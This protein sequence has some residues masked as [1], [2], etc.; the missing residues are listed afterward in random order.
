M[1]AAAAPAGSP[2]PLFMWTV[3]AD[4]ATVHLLGSVHVGAPDFYPLDV[5]I[6]EAFAASDGLAVEIDLTDPATVQRSAQLFLQRAMY[7]ADESLADHV[8]PETYQAL[9][10][11][12]KTRP[13]PLMVVSRM[14]PAAVAVFLALEEM[15]RL[16][17]DPQLGVDVHFLNRARRSCEVRALETVEQQIDAIFGGAAEVEE[18]L[19][20]EVLTQTAV[21]DSAMAATVTAWQRGDADQMATLI[22][23]QMLDDAR[24]RGFHERILSQRNARMFGALEEFLA[25]DETWFVVVG[26]AHLVGSDGLI[27]RLTEAGYPVVQAHAAVRSEPARAEH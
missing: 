10:K 26:A 15:K 1:V 6:E 24:L 5:T 17:Y 18:L 4:S 7:P 13:V 27:A 8:A 19:L 2:Q 14:R 16:G 12:A 9:E 25:G 11:Y 22:E 21:L 20:Q 23:Q 3:R